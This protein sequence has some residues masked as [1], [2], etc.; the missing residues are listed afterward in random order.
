[1]YVN[2]NLP[3]HPTLSFTYCVYMSILYICVSIP[4]LGIGSSVPVFWIAYPCFNTQYYFFWLTSLYVTDSRSIYIFTND[5]PNMEHFTT[6]GVILCRGHANLYVIPILVFVLPKRVL[7]KSFDATDSFC[8]VLRHLLS[9]GWWPL[10]LV[11]KVGPTFWKSWGKIWVWCQKGETEG[12]DHCLPTPPNP[13]LSLPRPGLPASRVTADSPWMKSERNREQG[14]ADF[15]ARNLTPECPWEQVLSLGVWGCGKFPARAAVWAQRH[16]G[17]GGFLGG[18]CSWPH[19]PHSATWTLLLASLPAG[20]AQ[21]EPPWRSSAVFPVMPNTAMLDWGPGR[22]GQ[23]SRGP[24]FGFR[25]STAKQEAC[26]SACFLLVSFFPGKTEQKSSTLMKLKGGTCVLKVQRAKQ[27]RTRSLGRVPVVL[28][29][30]Q[31][32]ICSAR[33]EQKGPAVWEFPFTQWR[34]HSPSFAQSSGPP[35]PRPPAPE[36]A[37]E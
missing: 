17:A 16:P 26:L 1:M 3:I 8:Q 10:M 22:L 4:T 33:G 25:G 28:R 36:S 37:T 9:G 18:R 32:S 31:H 2:P 29:W 30:P 34:L 35:W 13:R 27:A 21:K 19:P 11:D 24:R 6:L 23:E 20:I 15:K 5:P 12:Y 14:R 7:Q